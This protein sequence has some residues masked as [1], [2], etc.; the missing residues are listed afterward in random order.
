MVFFKGSSPWASIGGWLPLF[1]LTGIVAFWTIKEKRYQFIKWIL[2]ISTM[3]AFVPFLNSMF[4][5][6]RSE[7]YARWFYMPIL[8]MCLATA[9]ALEKSRKWALQY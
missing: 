9:I 7:Y 4:Y 8:I 6:F 1:G 2:I 3:I 5:L